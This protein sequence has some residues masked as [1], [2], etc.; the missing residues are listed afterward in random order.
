M[1]TFT[2]IV[3]SFS[4]SPVSQQ[5]VKA[6]A[7][8]FGVEGRYATA[9]YSAATKLKQLEGV[10]KE[11]LS[12][13]DALKSDIK[14]R[15]F[16]LDPTIQKPLKVEALKSIAQKKNFSAASANL[17]AL[18]AENGRIKSIDA[19]ISNFSIIMSAHR[20]DLPVEVVTARPLEEADRTELQNTLKLFAK[21]GENILLTTKVDPS[22]IGGM[23]V[24]IGDR[25]VDMSV[26]S[27]VKKYTDLLQAAA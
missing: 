6:P 2:T 22:I 10:E 23:I 25:Y 5:L 21:K 19:V 4:S 15:D 11:L 9:L 14:F 1:A 27:K 24:S 7:Q 12:F 13:Q 3:R 8:V 17:L 26:A 20:G 16:V 18:L